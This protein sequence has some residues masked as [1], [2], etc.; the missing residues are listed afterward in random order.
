MDEYPSTDLDIAPQF[1]IIKKNLIVQAGSTG[2]NHTES[3]VT[4]FTIPYGNLLEKTDS[5]YYYLTV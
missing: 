5:T 2:L 4:S 1:K 3:F